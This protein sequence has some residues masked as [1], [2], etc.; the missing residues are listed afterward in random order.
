ML[1]EETSDST[2]TLGDWTRVR[3]LEMHEMMLGSAKWSQET[4]CHL[5]APQPPASVRT[6]PQGCGEPGARPT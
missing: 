5:P 2:E 6:P 1:E 3:V 4:L